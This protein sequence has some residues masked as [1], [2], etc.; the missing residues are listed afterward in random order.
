[1]KAIKYQKKSLIKL[2]DL[3][4]RRKSNLKKFLQDR[5]ITNYTALEQVC[6]RLGVSPPT[7]E[8]FELVMPSY[9]SDPASGVIVVPPLDVIHES[10]GERENSDE[11]FEPVSTFASLSDDSIPLRK[12]QK[13]KAV[14]A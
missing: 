13:R 11:T 9:V 6:S 1:M 5:G 4:R 14:D 8:A 12:K 2:E 7:T 3:L 10:T